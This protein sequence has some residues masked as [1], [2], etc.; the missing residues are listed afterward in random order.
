MLNDSVWGT[1]TDWSAV[2]EASWPGLRSSPR[3]RR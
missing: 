2:A 1:G 3:I